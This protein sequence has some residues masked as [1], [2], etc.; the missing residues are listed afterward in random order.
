MTH[1]WSAAG[2][3]LNRDMPEGYRAERT[4]IVAAEIRTVESGTKSIVIFRVGVEW[5][6]LPTSIFQEVT[7]VSGIHQLPHR[8]GGILS[9]LVNVRGELILCVALDAM[10]G[11]EKRRAENGLKG[12]RTPER[13]LVCNRKGNV[14]AFRVNE[15]HGVQQY[16]PQDLKE[17]PA[18]LAKAAATYTVGMVRWKEKTVGCLDDE[19]LF[20]AFSKGLA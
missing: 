16:H 20:Y 14:V 7:E 4:D 15:V 19:L 17:V 12:Q 1:H 11:F 5:L 18:T 10:L 6:A 9:G 2:K 13:L 8:A 3:L